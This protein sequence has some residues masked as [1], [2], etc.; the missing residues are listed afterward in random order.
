[1]PQSN[2]DIAVMMR[3]WPGAEPWAEHHTEPPHVRVP[4]M[5]GVWGAGA[6]MVV[7]SGVLGSV[8]LIPHREGFLKMAEGA[9]ARKAVRSVR[10]WV[11]SVQRARSVGCVHTADADPDP[12]PIPAVG[13]HPALPGCACP[14]NHSSPSAHEARLAAHCGRGG[15]WRQSRVFGSRSPSRRRNFFRATSHEPFVGLK[16]A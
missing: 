13:E 5:A 3:W 12:V 15:V 1:M 7:A 9:S 14:H 11:N 16:A 4:R 8:A 6:P 2:S 10:N